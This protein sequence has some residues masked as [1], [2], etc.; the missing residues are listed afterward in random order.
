MPRR[1][2]ARFLWITLAVLV[3]L[4]VASYVATSMWVHSFLRSD[5]FRKLISAKTGA[6]FNSDA[7][8]GPLRWAGSSVHSDSFV[9][10]GLAGS[11]LSKVQADQI[12]A[13]VN[14]RAIFDG[15][16]RVDQVDVVHLDGSFR[17]GGEIKSGDVE[18][19]A[20]PPVTG[21][22]KWLPQRFELG[23]LTVGEANL[24]FLGANGAQAVGVRRSQVQL[25]PDGEGWMIEGRAGT[26]TVPSVPE[27]EIVDFRSRMQRDNFFL[28]DSHFRL[29]DT[30]KISASGEFGGDST[31]R[32]DWQQI[33]LAKLLNSQWKEQLSGMLDGKATL[34]WPSSGLSAAKVTGSF[35]ITEALLQKLPVLEQV[36]VFTGA[37]QFRRMP[38][39]DIAGDYYYKDGTLTV[40]NFMA[41]SK[42]LMRV[43]G[44]GHIDVNG[45][46]AGVFRVGVTPQTLQ[47]L[48]GSRE[49]V[50]VTARNGYLWTDVR[51]E[52]TVQNL[53]EDLS[54]R[55]AN[56]LKDEA[57]QRGAKALENLPGA[58]KE[59]VSGALEIL[60]PLLR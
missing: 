16:W 31:L 23:L 21:L 40:S 13:E 45:Q 44:E 58:A 12:R 34:Q 50:F 3:L 39:Q 19:S 15:A 38:L 22:A 35:H 8:Y 41:E 29:G 42:G 20:T 47:W 28:T 10:T 43:E 1:S 57:I 52:G 26:L 27:L 6:A 2:P 24:N 36:A 33:D 5:D 55:L 51:V 53:R 14:W 49:R 54:G 46:L 11:P 9:A 60:G 30:G 56:A 32:L 37:P 25:R 17:P 48:P 4:V 59:G 7:S 18:K